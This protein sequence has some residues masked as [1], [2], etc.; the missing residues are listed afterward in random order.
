MPTR[1]LK[2]G[3]RDSERIDALDPIT[4]TLY[5]RL[6]VTVDDFGRYDARPSMVKSACFPVKDSVTPQ[7]VA[8]MLNELHRNE[9]ITLYAV[10]GKPYL[11]MQKWDN[12]PRAA[13]SNYP[14]CHTFDVHPHTLADNPRASAPVTG[15][16]TG[17]GT[18]GGASAPIGGK[19]PRSSGKA[20]KTWRADDVE[21]PPWLA[22]E[23]WVRWCAD[24]RK[25]S[26]PI[27]E[28]AARL[29]LLQLHK[30]RK[31]GHQPK[32]V[33]DHSIAGGF[34]G[35]YP[36][37]ING[38]ASSAP[39]HKWWQD[40]AEVMKRAADHG[41][42]IAP[43]LVSEPWRRATDYQEWRQLVVET[44]KAAGGGADDRPPW[45]K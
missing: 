43:E 18:V 39:E 12:K 38:T 10:A 42:Q 45:V 41:I 11:Q 13:E 1:Y 36:P 31:E 34:Q 24:R 6:I 21:L 2:P 14:E 44:W 8:T 5:Y 4:E 23:D 3:I 32:A 17:T 27:T 28:E 29:Q 7:H 20:T 9:L 26:K 22:R 33:I 15:T 30:Y 19:P 35:L 16:G 25:R 37:K 40:Q